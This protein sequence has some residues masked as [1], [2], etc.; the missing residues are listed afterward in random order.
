MV[1]PFIEYTM[2]LRWEMASTVTLAAVLVVVVLLSSSMVTTVGPGPNRSLL[3]KVTAPFGTYVN[4]LGRTGYDEQLDWKNLTLPE[5]DAINTESS[6]GTSPSPTLYSS[7]IFSNDNPYRASLFT[8]VNLSSE[9][10]AYFV[11]NGTVEPIH[12]WTPLYVDFAFNGLFCNDLYYA[13][14]TPS[15]ELSDIWTAGIPSSGVFGTNSLIYVEM[16]DYLNG[17]Y[18]LYNTNVTYGEWTDGSPDEALPIEDYVGAITDDGWFAVNSNASGSQ[19]DLFANWSLVNVYSG[20]RLEEPGYRSSYLQSNSMTYI[21]DYGVMETDE[22]GVGGTELFQF[23]QFNETNLSVIYANVTVTSPRIT[24]SD[25]NNEPLY[26]SVLPNGTIIYEGFYELDNIGNGLVLR[27]PQ[28]RE[29]GGIIIYQTGSS[30]LDIGHTNLTVFWT[31]LP[32]DSNQMGVGTY[33]TDSGDAIQGTGWLGQ[34]FYNLLNYTSISGA[35]NSS[36]INDGT[37]DMGSLFQDRVA[38]GITADVSGHFSFFVNVPK[39]TY[40]SEMLT[41]YWLPSH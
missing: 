11:S 10:V 2:T 16:Y 29:Y 33:R 1:V 13:I 20:Q 24:G 23:A 19:Y 25:W 31:Q 5:I 17:S 12:S 4:P 34:P 39:T 37:I 22:E 14:E 21:P 32:L 35:G 36:W 40:S 7:P 30:I 38:V 27:Q 8:Y 18:V 28:S 15:G 3:G 26:Y 9:L 41:L 6:S